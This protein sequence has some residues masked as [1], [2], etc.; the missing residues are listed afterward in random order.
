MTVILSEAKDLEAYQE[1]FFA[2]AGPRITDNKKT[3][4]WR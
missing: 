1:R 4:T 3:Y 2:L